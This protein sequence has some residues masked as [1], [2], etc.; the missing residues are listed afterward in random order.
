VF[1]FVVLV[2]GSG[3][4][5]RGE[6]RREMEG[7]N[8]SGRREWREGREEGGGKIEETNETEEGRGGGRRRRLYILSKI[9]EVE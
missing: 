6:G 5:K 1:V 4:E 2:E 8:R 3:R 9:R 7:Q